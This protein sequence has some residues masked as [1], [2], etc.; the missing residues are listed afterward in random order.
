MPG[1]EKPSEDRQEYLEHAG[2]LIPVKKGSFADK[3]SQHPRLTGLGCLVLSAI[4]AKWE[5]FDVIADPKNYGDAG[6][7]QQHD[8]IATGLFLGL[9]IALLL[10]GRTVDNLLKAG[11]VNQAKTSWKTWLLALCC[12]IPALFMHLWLEYQLFGASPL[13]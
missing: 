12:F 2:E 6:R 3:T 4:F 5:I 11:G 8:V 1:P 9:G 7:G 10:G 13:K